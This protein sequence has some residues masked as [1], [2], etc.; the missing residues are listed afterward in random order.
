MEQQLVIFEVENELY[1]VDIANVE[2]IIR[3]QALTHLPNTPR[4]ID[5][6]TNLRGEVVP[7]INLRKR[8]SME[9][10]EPTR[11]TRIMI[12]NLGGVKAGLVVDA[13]AQVSRITEEDMEVPPQMLQTSHSAF[14]RSIAHLDEHLVILLDLAKVLTVEE[15]ESLATL[16]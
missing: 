16:A 12:A 13:V 10:K 7:I 9:P 8:F 5:G 14:I 11:E 3:M 6:V 1:G 15:K 4:F 2:S